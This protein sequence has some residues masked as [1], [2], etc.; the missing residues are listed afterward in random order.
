[1]RGEDIPPTPSG[2]ETEPQQPVNGSDTD[3][4]GEESSESD[5]GD[6]AVRQAEAVWAIWPKRIDAMAALVAI[7]QAIQTDGLEAVLSGT[8]AIVETDA[9]RGVSPP[10]R[11]LPKP[12]EFFGGRRYLD[13]PAQ[14]GPRNHGSAASVP[15][16]IRVRELAD[17]LASQEAGSRDWWKLHREV[18]ALRMELLES[19]SEPLA[20]RLREGAELLR[21]HVGNPEN[22]MGGSLEGKRKAEDE[23]RALRAKWKSLRKL[24]RATPANDAA[25]CREP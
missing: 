8:R 2:G 5:E 18:Q 11:Y 23:F 20:V 17:Q 13:D 9:R 22:A 14:Y 7:R 25:E 1:M 3:H 16:G 10:G 15:I 21:L 4:P 24:I 12:T 19:D 6:D